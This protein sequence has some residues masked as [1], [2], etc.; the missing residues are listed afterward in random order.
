MMFGGVGAGGGGGVS[1]GPPSTHKTS[2]MSLGKH[3]LYTGMG[4]VHR[5]SQCGIVM[6]CGLDFRF[7]TL[8]IV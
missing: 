2:F 8:M 4:H 1:M 5:S 6:F 7:P 3:V